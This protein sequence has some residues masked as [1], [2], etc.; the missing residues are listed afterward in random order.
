[1]YLD[2]GDVDLDDIDAIKRLE[3]VTDGKKLPWEALHVAQLA[4][5]VM[6]QS[7]FAYRRR[8]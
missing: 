8:Y 3:E 2:E 6:P 7:I 5:E 4:Q 1:M